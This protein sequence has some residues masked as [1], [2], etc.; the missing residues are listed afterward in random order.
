MSPGFQLSAVSR[1]V[2]LGSEPR[3]GLG[4][5]RVR[6]VLLFWGMCQR[7]DDLQEMKES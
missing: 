6:M 1:K 2:A 3:A 4:V 5:A 7:L